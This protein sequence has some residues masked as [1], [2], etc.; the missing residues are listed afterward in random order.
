MDY[1]DG[2]GLGIEQIILLLGL[3]IIL[4]AVQ[5]YLGKKGKMKAGLWLLVVPFVISILAVIYAF[6]FMDF[7]DGGRFTTAFSY[8]VRINIITIMLAAIHSLYFGKRRQ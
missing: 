5:I 2:L 8:F 1:I 7:P 4:I 3:A 6:F